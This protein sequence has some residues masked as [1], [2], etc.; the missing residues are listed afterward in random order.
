[1]VIVLFFVPA[2]FFPAPLF[3]APLFSPPLVVFASFFPAALDLRAHVIRL[4][5]RDLESPDDQ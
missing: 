5:L 2:T 1:V 4:V 3:L